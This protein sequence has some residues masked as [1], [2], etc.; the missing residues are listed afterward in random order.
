MIAAF[1]NAGVVVLGG[2]LGLLLGSRLK[3]DF[4]KTIVTALGICTMVIGI[5]SAIATEDVILMIV[6]LVIGI[7]IGQLLKIEHTLDAV[8][9]Q[10][11]AKVAKNDG[12]RFT[13]GFVTASLLFCVGS[14]AVLGSFDAGVRG[15]YTTIFAKS[16]L[17][18]MM[19]MTF[20]ATMGVGV[21]FSGLTILVYQ[22]ALTLLASVIEPYLSREMLTEMNAVGGVMLIATGMNV[23]G[24][25]KERIQV[26]NMLP[27]LLVPVV[28][29]WL[30]QL[31]G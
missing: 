9:D 7:V 14:M 21:L 11:K 15:D 30:R 3:E 2:L 6:S 28:W 19:A 26:G 24:L 10:L 4:T 20:A 13:E 22:G 1:V 12:G 5:S 27:A 31:L 25:H 16:A 8:G 29:F 18:F 23:M 17:D